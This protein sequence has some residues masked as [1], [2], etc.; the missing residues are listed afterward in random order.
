MGSRLYKTGDLARYLPDGNIEFL[1]RIYHQVKIRGFRI[2]LGEI[3]AVLSQHPD[4]QES[5]VINREDASGNQRL[6]AYILSN[7]RPERVPYQSECLTE[8]GG[9]P[10]VKL[11]T[12]DISTG[13]V[14]IVGVPDAYQPSQPLRLYLCLPGCTEEQWLEGRIV[15][16]Q[17]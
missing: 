5:L 11:R 1:G 9:S 6:V 8:F 14:C 10:A 12:E 2:E 15:W 3:E 7:L 16:R 17:G 13:G 4:V